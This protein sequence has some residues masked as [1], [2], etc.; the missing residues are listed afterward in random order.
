MKTKIIT[1][2][3]FAFLAVVLFIGLPMMIS[4]CKEDPKGL[5]GPYPDSNRIHLK[6]ITTLKGEFYYIIEVDGY[7]YLTS[8]RGGFIALPKR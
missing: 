8:A 5:F 4:S 2:I 3:F 7:E 6:E 1:V